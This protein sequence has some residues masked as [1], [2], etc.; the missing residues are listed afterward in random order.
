MAQFSS[1]DRR[2]VSLMVSVHPNNLSLHHI[3]FFAGRSG[4]QHFAQSVSSSS[5]VRIEHLLRSKQVRV[6][7]HFYSAFTALHMRP[8]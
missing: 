1:F 5:R 3:A 4:I 8:G 2:V 7:V 6:V